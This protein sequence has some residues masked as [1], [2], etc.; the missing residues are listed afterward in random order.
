MFLKPAPGVVT[1]HDSSIKQQSEGW[2]AGEAGSASSDGLE[3]S[4]DAGE[5]RHEEGEP[6]KGDDVKGDAPAKHIGKIVDR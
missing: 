5:V 1:D 6:E 4:A 3:E 2:R